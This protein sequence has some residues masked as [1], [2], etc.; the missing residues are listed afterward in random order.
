[1]IKLVKETI[2][3]ALN[4]SGITRIIDIDNK[5]ILTEKPYAVFQFLGETFEKTGFTLS[6]EVK[7]GGTT[8]V[9][10]KYISKLS[11]SCNIVT[12]TE[13]E[14]ISITES[15]IKNIPS[16]LRDKNNNI[17]SVTMASSTY[18][19]A[20]GQ[21]IGTEIVDTDPYVSRVINIDFNYHIIEKQGTKNMELRSLTDPNLNKE[22]IIMS[23]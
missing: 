15:F 12:Q 3:D 9:S 19:L 4:K 8:K 21:F 20:S 10:S 5:D 2:T 18:K 22:M 16:K 13:N 1:M 17:V 11:V 6:G 7:E 14:L 23:K